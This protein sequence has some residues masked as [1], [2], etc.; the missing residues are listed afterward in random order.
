ML[1]KNAYSYKMY[2]FVDPDNGSDVGDGGSI[3]LKCTVG[4]V[5]ETNRK[6]V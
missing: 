6:E 1:P 2:L 3:L 5:V 4:T